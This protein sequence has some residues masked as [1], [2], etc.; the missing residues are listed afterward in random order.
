M[1]AKIKNFITKV[2]GFCA[3]Q[4]VNFY[5]GMML[6]V[7]FIINTPFLPILTGTLL[8]PIFS[9][10]TFTILWLLSAGKDATKEYFFKSELACLLGSIWV[11]IFAL[12]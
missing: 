4:Q 10:L 12:F 2:K 11:M 5:V 7:L 3:T 1:G 8:A 9:S 6:C